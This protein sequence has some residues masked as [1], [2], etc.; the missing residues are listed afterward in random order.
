MRE[1][2]VSVE[3]NK[4]T[5]KYIQK[6]FHNFGYKV[7]YKTTNKI[8][9]VTR[10]KTN[11]MLMDT[12]VYKLKCSDCPAFYLG[13]TGRSFK[14]RFNEHIS[15]IKRIKP[16]SR[17]AL[18]IKI[19]NHHFESID[20][21][22]EILHRMA[23]GDNLDRIEELEIYKERRN[24]QLLNN[25]INTETNKIYDL[26]INNTQNTDHPHTQNSK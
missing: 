22:M 16:E 6:I 23:K 17:F 7:G 20:N 13:Q 9:R 11:E 2:Y 8:E 18:H 3:Y 10:R 24:I 14:L 12:G 4:Y 25:K 26:I 15:E 19:S 5:S 1:R 21:N